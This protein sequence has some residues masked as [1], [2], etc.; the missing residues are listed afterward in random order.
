[1]IGLLVEVGASLSA[2]GGSGSTSAHSATSA[3]SASSPPSSSLSTTTTSTTVVVA[4]TACQD[5]QLRIAAGK[6]GAAGGSAGQTILFTNVGKT[7]CSITG[8]PGVAALDA[9]GHQVAQAQR[10]LNGML[11]GVQI[12]STPALVTLQPGQVASAEIEGVDHPVGTATSCPIYP[13][14]LVTLPD[15]TQSAT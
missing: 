10:Q 6:S 14:F 11:G 15:G 13:A 5:A 1:V 7:A 2:C 4:H 8:Y 9:Q 12:G 3:P